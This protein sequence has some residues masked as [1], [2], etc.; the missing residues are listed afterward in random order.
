MAGIARGVLRDYPDAD[1]AVQN[2]FINVHRTW[3]TV[4][5]LE[6]AA[7]QRAYL[8]QAVLHESYRIWNDRRDRREVPADQAGDFWVVQWD[9]AG[10]ISA[11]IDLYRVW[12]VVAGFPEVLRE[13]MSLFIA[14]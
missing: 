9:G 11:K 10:H 14:G 2:A 1:D 13:V 4:G 7:K 6:T 3:S 5:Q 8:R 12:K